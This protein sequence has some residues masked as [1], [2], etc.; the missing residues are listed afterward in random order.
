MKINY[1]ISHLH[2][3]QD[4]IFGV[5]PHPSFYHQPH[6]CSFFFPPTLSKTNTI[7]KTFNSLSLSLSPSVY[8]LEF[9]EGK[10]EELM[11]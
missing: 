3:F 6:L 11:A 9:E 2:C 5:L 8:E 1:P 7:S 10:Q 4:F